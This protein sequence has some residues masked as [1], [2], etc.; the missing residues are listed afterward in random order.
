MVLYWN[1]DNR[2][3]YTVPVDEALWRI[4]AS[5]DSPSL[6]QIMAW[7]M[8]GAKPLSEPMLEY[9]LLEPQEQTSV[10]L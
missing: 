5:V 2:K 1:R 3:I 6:D 9:C 10:Q 4:Y 8:A 7:P